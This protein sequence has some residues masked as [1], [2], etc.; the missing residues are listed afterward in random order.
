MTAGTTI[1]NKS[2]RNSGPTLAEFN[3]NS[4]DF[5]TYL[6]VSVDFA[7]KLLELG[8]KSEKIGDRVQPMFGQ[9]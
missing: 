9:T 4:N 1:G 8:P 7:P 3:H 6:V 5:G 2:C